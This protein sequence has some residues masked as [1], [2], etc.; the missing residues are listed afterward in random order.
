MITSKVIIDGV[1]YNMEDTTAREQIREGNGIVY[2][3]NRN[4]GTVLSHNLEDLMGFYVS[5]TQ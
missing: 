4:S 3:C 2:L 5:N 1:P